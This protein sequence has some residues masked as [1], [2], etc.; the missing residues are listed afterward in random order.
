V[1][2]ESGEIV[3][4]KGKMKDGDRVFLGIG[5]GVEEIVEMISS[6]I[7]SKEMEERLLKPGCGVV[8]DFDINEPDEQMD[9]KIDLVEEKKELI[10]KNPSFGEI[11]CRC[12][13]ITK[14]ELLNAINNPLGVKTM[15]GIKRRCRAGMGRCQG[16]FCT[17]RTIKILRKEYGIKEKDIL[18]NENNSNLFFGKIKE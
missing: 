5:E 12:E 8:M 16:G 3:V 4:Q 1:L 18:K 10:K 2:R 13:T 6:E 17:P 14:G 9:T 11:I 15:D 7:K